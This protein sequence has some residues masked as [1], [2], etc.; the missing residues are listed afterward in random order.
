[1]LAA[2]LITPNHSNYL[3]GLVIAG[4]WKHCGRDLYYS[5]AANEAKQTEQWYDPLDR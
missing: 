5:E 2:P 4:Y 3:S 1:M